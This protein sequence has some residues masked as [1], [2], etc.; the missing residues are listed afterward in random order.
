MKLTFSFFLLL[1][2]TASSAIFAQ[3]KKPNII[4]IFAD[5]LGYGELGCYGQQKIE[6]PNLDALA[7][8][9]KKFVQFYSGTSVCAPSR[10]SLMTGLHTGHTPIRGNKQFE[11]EGQTPLPASTK[12]F[13]NYL[14]QNGYATATFGKWGMGFNQNSGDPNKKGFALFYGYNDQSLAHDFYPPYLWNNHNKVDL[15]IN[16]QYDS[17]YSAALIHQQAVQYINRQGNKPFFMYLS[18][19]LPH[20]DVIGPHDSLY[21]YYKQKFNEQPL[22]GA[23]LKTRPHNMQPEPYPHA[24]FAAMVGRLDLYVGEIVKAIKEKG[25]EENTL[26]IFSSDNGPHRENG[27]DPEFFNSNGI[28]RGIKRDLYE[29][30]MRVPFI[31]YWPT[32]I[33]PAVIEK[34]FALWDMYPTFLEL[35]KIPVTEKIDGIS[36]VPTLL[37]NSKQ[38]QHEY[39]YWEFHENNGRQ[40]VLWGKWKG[41]RLNVNKQDDAPVE[42]YDLNTDPSE[43]KN[44]A[45][46]YPAVV[47]KI[48]Q[49]M[50]QAHTG[51]SDWPL[52]KSEFGK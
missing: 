1:F 25:L 13:A 51:N 52:L 27:G 36:I 29:G 35:A 22:T 8:K 40:A 46:Q 24:Q 7:A 37:N 9:G 30:G 6:T 50:K 15:S 26:I 19:T 45:A 14:Q 41:V 48:K 10:A 34:P 42:L 21:N 32:K 23:A 3:N 20:G 47:E 28:Y 33:K 44:L 38:K 2:V 12:T 43:E 16:K 4:F 31:A 49:F 39:F 17:V 5:D 18:Y 11:P